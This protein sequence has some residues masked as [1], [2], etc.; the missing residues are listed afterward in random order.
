M[1]VS[2]LSATRLQEIQRLYA[3]R[4][5]VPSNERAHQAA[6][7]DGHCLMETGVPEDGWGSDARPYPAIAAARNEKRYYSHTA[8]PSVRYDHPVIR[9]DGRIGWAMRAAS[10][11][12]WVSQVPLWNNAVTYPRKLFPVDRSTQLHGV[13]ADDRRLLLARND[14]ILTWDTQPGI[15]LRLARVFHPQAGLETV[16]TLSR[17]VEGLDALSDG[18]VLAFPDGDW[19]QTCYVVQPGV[20]RAIAVPLRA[21]SPARFARRVQHAL[22][23]LGNGDVEPFVEQAPFLVDDRGD[24]GRKEWAAR[25]S[26]HAVALAVP[27]EGDRTGLFI[28][29]GSALS[30]RA[31]LPGAD[32]AWVPPTMAW[33]EDGAQVYVRQGD[34]TETS[35]RLRTAIVDVATGRVVSVPDAWDFSSFHASPDGARLGIVNL[36]AQVWMYEKATGVAAEVGTLEPAAK[37]N[38]RPVLHWT[39][40]GQQAVITYRTQGADQRAVNVFGVDGTRC[41]FPQVD[42]VEVRDDAL[43]IT[44]G[45]TPHTLALPLDM[46][47]LAQSEWFQHSC[48]S[49]ILGGAALP[50]LRAGSVERAADHVTIGGVVVPI[51]QDVGGGTGGGVGATLGTA[52]TTGSR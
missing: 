30:R 7:P 32:L 52:G 33:S 43:D 35:L 26:D 40:D 38:E 25:D 5:D 4:L 16:G 9:S 31:T 44:V 50:K 49:A 39:R 6:T 22:P 46:A 47:A 42:R 20:A 14:E 45:G 48:E 12:T 37:L 2:G 41:I 3:R 29:D 15:G 23:F 18:S 27:E 8:R 19:T 11:T 13:S 1:H 34:L 51:R 24:V 28:W 10:E 36:Y 21:L 17:R